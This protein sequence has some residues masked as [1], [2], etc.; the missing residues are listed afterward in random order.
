MR[1][2]HWLPVGGFIF[3]LGSCSR[4]NRAGPLAA[5]LGRETVWSDAVPNVQLDVQLEHHHF[6]LQLRAPLRARVCW[7]RLAKGQCALC[8]CPSVSACTSA[9]R[10]AACWRARHLSITTGLRLAARPTRQC[11]L[12][13]RLFLLLPRLL[14]GLGSC[15]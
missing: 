4:S 3:A 8:C 15:V 11:L 14:V 12:L 1:A 7:L 9:A 2:R 13:S 6:A 10:A 5:K